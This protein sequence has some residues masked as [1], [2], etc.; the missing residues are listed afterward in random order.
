[1]FLNLGSDSGIA[2]IYGLYALGLG[3]MY[4]QSINADEATNKVLGALIFQ[5]IQY[6]LMAALAPT[7]NTEA[8]DQAKRRVEQLQEAFSEFYRDFSDIYTP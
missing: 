7:D 2:S 5:A 4:C 8:Q 6:Q 3:R 1:M